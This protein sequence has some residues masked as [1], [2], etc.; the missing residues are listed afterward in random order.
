MTTEE[1]ERIRN[2]H[3]IEAK[4]ANE[5]GGWVAVSHAHRGKLL[6][7]VD[8]LAALCRSA[9]VALN[10][11]SEA[12]SAFADCSPD[13]ADQRRFTKAMDE[14]EEALYEHIQLERG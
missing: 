2:E 5:R 12:V 1:L 13:P 4:V 3:E 9:Q 10:A 11:A 7:E 6:A 8:R 14:L